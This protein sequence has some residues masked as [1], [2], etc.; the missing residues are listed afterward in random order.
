MATYQV[1]REHIGHARACSPKRSELSHERNTPRI[2]LALGHARTQPGARHSSGMS[3]RMSC[4]SRRAL[5]QGTDV[6]IVHDASDTHWQSSLQ[7]PAFVRT[8][9]AGAPWR[10]R[11]Q[12]LWPAS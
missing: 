7:R 2:R 10:G 12:M 9:E 3:H 8:H 11:Q 6:N 5:R 4:M 1:A